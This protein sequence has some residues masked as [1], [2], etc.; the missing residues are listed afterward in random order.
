M[1]PGYSRKNL[2]WGLGLVVLGL[3]GMSLLH[4]NGP[5]MGPFSG[6]GTG[7]FFDKGSC[8]SNGE[9]IY[10]LGID[11]EGERIPTRGG[12]PWLYPMG[13]SCVNCHGPD[14]LGGFSIMMGTKVPGDIRYTSLTSEEHG[15][16]AKDADESHRYTEEDIKRA[17]T[18]G[19]AP[20]GDRFD[21]TM[22]RWKL[23]RE[24]L[25]DLIDFLKDL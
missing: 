3:S 21:P 25:S 20:D 1:N 8:A 14:G 13:G 19:V 23:D 24:D 16:D 6:W 9:R 18:E 12:P 5:G 4:G 10:Y 15:H 22:P 2:W 11:D 17:I 7:G